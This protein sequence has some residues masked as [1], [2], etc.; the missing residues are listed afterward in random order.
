[1]KNSKFYNQADLMIRVLP[2]V[3]GYKE[4]ALKG[5]AALNLF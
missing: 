5:G 4:V 3:T 1:M 2:I